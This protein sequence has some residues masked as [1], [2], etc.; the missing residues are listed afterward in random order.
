VTQGFP[1][2]ETALWAR[3]HVRLNREGFR[4]T[5]HVLARVPGTERVLLIG[6][7]FAFGAGIRRT[8]GRLGEQLALR[9]DSATRTSWEVINASHPDLH[10]LNEIAILDSTISYRPDVVILE[11]VFNDIDYLRPVTTRTGL[12]EAPETVLQRVHPLRLLFKNSFLFQEVYVRI[13]AISWSLGRWDPRDDAYADTSVVRIHLA[14]LARFVTT[15]VTAGAIVG[16]VPVDPSVVGS[17]GARRRYESFVDR[18]LAGGLPIWRMDSAFHG[19]TMTQLAVNRLDGHP[20]ELANRLLATAILPR[21]L[22]EL[23]R[24]KKKSGS[25]APLSTARPGP[26]RGTRSVR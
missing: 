24:N 19:F 9:L 16:I 18:A 26:N 15:A 17:R 6:D 5:E 12:T 13:R 21:V 1:S 20:N 2:Y 7:S 10:T 25:P 22:H 4:D 8:E 3:R 14:D 11:Y 23:Q